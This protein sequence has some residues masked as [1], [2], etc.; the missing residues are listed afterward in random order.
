MPY[1]AIVL[2]DQDSDD[3]F[4]QEQGM[5]IGLSTPDQMKD[6]VFK[7]VED[8]PGHYFIKILDMKAEMVDDTVK[9]VVMPEMPA[10]GRRVIE[11]YKLEIK[12]D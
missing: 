5:T 2:K 1:C 6:F 7:T 10:I 12:D 8:Q 3:P 9:W 4:V 11:E